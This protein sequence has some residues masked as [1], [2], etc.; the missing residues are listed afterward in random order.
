MYLSIV[1]ATAMLAASG[2]A[3]PAAK[4]STP[5]PAKHSHPT[6]AVMH[7]DCYPACIKMTADGSDC[8]KTKEVCRDICG[9]KPEYPK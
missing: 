5:P 9:E 3:S 6:C 8:A 1:L 7:H 4:Q 2:S